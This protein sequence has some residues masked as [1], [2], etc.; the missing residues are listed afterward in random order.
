MLLLS[1]YKQVFEEFDCIE[2]LFS[3]GQAQYVVFLAKQPYVG[4]V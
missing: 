2:L 4:I 1:Y 3:C